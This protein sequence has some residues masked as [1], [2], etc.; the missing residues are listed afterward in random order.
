MSDLPENGPAPADPAW[1]AFA[2]GLKTS[3]ARLSE[4]AS[5]NQ[6]AAL[7]QRAEL[8]G[9]SGRAPGLSNWV[10]AGAAAVVVAVA[11]GTFWVVGPS[12]EQAWTATTVVSSNARIEATLT[13][14]AA[15]G[16]AL[17]AV[18]D[19]RIG[20]GPGTRVELAKASDR[21]T[22][23]VLSK[24][25]VAANVDHARGKRN[26]DVE[27]PLGRVHV[28]GTVFRVSAIDDALTVEVQQGTV[29]VLRGS[30]V[31]R[32]TAGQRLTVTAGVESVTARGDGDFEELSERAPPVAVVPKPAPVAQENPVAPPPQPEPVPV[33]EEPKRKPAASSVKLSEWRSRAARGECGLVMAEVK[34]FLAVTPDDVAVRLTLADCQRRSGDKTAALDSYLKASDGKGPDANRATFQAAS[35]LQDDLAQPARALKQ[36]ERYLSRGAES[37]DL[38]AS[39]MVRK[40]RAFKALGKTTQA[41][42]L[43]DQVLKKFGDTSAAP[44]ALRLKDQP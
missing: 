27:T 32:V 21:A 12:P 28:V 40:A 23:L 10:L 4:R 6:I 38:E 35:L 33:R 22:R 15:D 19:D 34:K 1:D 29:E 30:S 41:R 44:E 9:E 7:M 14:T 11:L 43:L 31:T 26:F 5:P 2:E 39:A 18:G 24:G 13:E 42:A 3:R 16:R 37:R 36:L 8:E 20:V 17:L 25:S